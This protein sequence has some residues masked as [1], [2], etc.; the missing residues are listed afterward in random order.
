MKKGDEKSKES[1]SPGF[2][3]GVISVILAV[4]SPVGGIIMG[5]VGLVFSRKKVYPEAKSGRVLN[6]IGIVLGI[7]MFILNVT[8]NLVLF[9]GGMFPS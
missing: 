9:Y 2:L 1:S 5:I 8:L 7:I 6:V 4:F 3:L